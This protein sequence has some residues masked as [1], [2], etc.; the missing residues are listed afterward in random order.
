LRLFAQTL[1]VKGAG[2]QIKS[3]A[4]EA[5]IASYHVDVAIDAK[6]A[7]LQEIPF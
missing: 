5:N 2:L 3:Q 4:L 6:F 1:S 7:P